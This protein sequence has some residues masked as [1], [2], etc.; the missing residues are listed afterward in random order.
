MRIPLRTMVPL[1]LG[2]E[3]V[4]L[5]LVSRRAA[6]EL[7]SESL[8]PGSLCLCSC[9]SVLLILCGFNEERTGPISETTVGHVDDQTYDEIG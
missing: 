5:R 8:Y 1:E 7:G 6:F 3:S 2:H 9:C 4:P